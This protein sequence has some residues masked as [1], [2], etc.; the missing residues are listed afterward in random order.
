MTANQRLAEI[1]LATG[2]YAGA[3]DHAQ[4]AYKT[5]VTNPVRGNC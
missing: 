1:E 5:D 4:T 2:D 3:L